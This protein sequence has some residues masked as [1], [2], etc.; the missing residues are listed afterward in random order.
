MR[1]CLQSNGMAK[2]I[3]RTSQQKSS[4]LDAAFLV[5]KGCTKQ[6]DLSE[7]TTRNESYWSF[8]TF[9]Y[10]MIASLDIE[11][12]VIRFMGSLRFD[13]W[14]VWC[15]VKM[16]GYKARFSY[17]PPDKDENKRDPTMPALTE[18]L[19]SSNWVTEEDDFLL[20][21]GSH[22]PDAAEKT[23]HCPPSR[24]DDEVFQFFVVRYVHFLSR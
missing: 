14:G 11:S 24:L 12:E 3:A 16:K 8:L 2:S 4:P 9:S 19:P 13:L 6:T 5:A 1:N 20:M 7:Y 23:Y 10:A 21:W 18:D 15:V 17:L 22:V